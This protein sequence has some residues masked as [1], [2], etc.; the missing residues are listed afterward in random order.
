[1]LQEFL[2]S[3]ISVGTATLVTNPFGELAMEVIPREGDS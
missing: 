2:V 3:G 1:M